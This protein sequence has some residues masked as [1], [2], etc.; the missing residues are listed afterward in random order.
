[1]IL[2]VVACFV[3]RLFVE[4]E[5]V[6]V[7]VSWCAQSRDRGHH[8]RGQVTSEPAEG[9][10]LRRSKTKTRL[11]KCTPI[12]NM[13]SFVFTTYSYLSILIVSRTYFDL[14]WYTS[15]KLGYALHLSIDN[16]PHTSYVPSTLSPLQP[17]TNELFMYVCKENAKM[18]GNRI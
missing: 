16:Q 8:G 7:V 6:D 18:D 3:Q 15:V 13:F 9:R 4:V 17:S 14:I 1:M 11:T 12:T 2:C 10:K 5:L